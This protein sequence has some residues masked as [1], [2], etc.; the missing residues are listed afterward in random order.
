LSRDYPNSVV[1]VRQIML[2]S[3]DIGI[4][5]CIKRVLVRRPSH[6]HI[7]YFL[8]LT[9]MPV[10]RC[11]HERLGGRGTEAYIVLRSTKKGLELGRA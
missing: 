3:C 4:P 11:D 10:L 5:I 1:R 7:L 2:W 9:Q 6:L 8:H